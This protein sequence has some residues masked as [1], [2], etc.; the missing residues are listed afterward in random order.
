[1]DIFD[2][3]KQIITERS[4]VIFEFGC[5]DGYHTNIL[6]GIADELCPSYKYYALEPDA[7]IFPCAQNIVKNKPS[8]TLMQ[9]AVHSISGVFEF[10]LSSGTGEDGEVCY[11]SSSLLK[12]ANVTKVWPRM[13]FDST[14]RVLCF[15]YDELFEDANVDRVDFIWADIQ[16]AEINLIAGG[17]R[18]LE[19]TRYFYTEYSNRGLYHG[20]APLET[21]FEALPGGWKIVKDF[22]GDVL[23]GNGNLENI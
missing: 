12:P 13:R 9:A 6:S 22:Q 4:A 3:Y 15:T 1:M 19:R 7:R 14:A 20:D 11:G 16:G 10:H 18:A 8:V 5:N 23:F 17:K 2:W 21:I